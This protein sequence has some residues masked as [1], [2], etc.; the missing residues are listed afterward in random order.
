[1]LSCAGIAAGRAVTIPS[2]AGVSG[3]P[4]GAAEVTDGVPRPSR[5]GGEPHGPRAYSTMCRC[6]GAQQRWQPKLR[7]RFPSHQGFSHYPGEPADTG[8]GVVSSPALPHSLG[9]WKRGR[10]AAG[11]PLPIRSCR[12]SEDD[13]ATVYRSAAML[14]MT[15][16]GYVWLVGEREISG[17]ALR[18]APDG[19]HLP[20][21]VPPQPGS[22]EPGGAGASGPSPPRDPWGNAVPWWS[23][24]EGPALCPPLPL[25]AWGHSLGRAAAPRIRVPGASLSPGGRLGPWGWSSGCPW[26]TELSP[27]GQ[28]Q[29]SPAAPACSCLKLR[30]L[31][32]ASKG[33]SARSR[34]L[35]VPKRWARSS[36]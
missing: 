29:P 17:N 13:A 6:A 10:R 28:S 11:A 14:N 15:G 18:Y 26:Y 2:V 16:S 5:E 32:T 36:R 7:G 21:S 1:M 33:S 23:R 22:E 24:T 8:T 12:C 20:S 4:A 35:A 3:C 9:M 34:V 30:Q 19:R 31:P 25:P 27:A